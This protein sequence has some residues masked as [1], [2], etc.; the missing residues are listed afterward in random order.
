MQATGQSFEVAWAVTRAGNLFTTHTA[1]AAGFDRFVPSLIE[2]YLGGYAREK[3]GITLHDLL[4]LGRENPT[5]PA[6]SFNMAYLAIRGS[7]AI[8]GVSR[9]HGKVS[10][11][12]FGP[13][14]P[15]WPL[16]EVPVGHVT[17]G[18]HMPTWDSAAADELWTKTCRKGPWLGTTEMLE[19]DIRRVSD[20][21]LWQFRTAATTA[22]VDYAR[23]RLSK[24]LAAS[25][26]S[27]EEV[28]GAKHLFDAHTLTLGFARRFATAA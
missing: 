5:D 6:E 4:A 17:N 10:R 19:Q 25:G 3:L 24:Q 14:F 20:A 11:R 8:N 26:A 1:V 2:H 23:E 16:E 22:L 27:P 21:G 9:L 18:V 13:L 12:L 15:R 28:D 7:E